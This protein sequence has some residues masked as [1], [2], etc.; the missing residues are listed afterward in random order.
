MIM[1]IT[2]G[3]LMLSAISNQCNHIQTATLLIYV[4]MKNLF[5]FD[6]YLCLHQEMFHGVF[7]C[8]FMAKSCFFSVP[9][10]ISTRYAYREEYI[11]I[12]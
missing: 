8:N 2:K 6:V 10:Y 4:H 1:V 5:T 11:E 3:Y 7:S 9:G 12:I